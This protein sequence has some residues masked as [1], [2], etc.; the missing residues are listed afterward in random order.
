MK[1]LKTECTISKLGYSF[2][3]FRSEPLCV[4]GMMD[5]AV[6]LERCCAVGDACVGD[7]LAEYTKGSVI[8][9]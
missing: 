4:F 3:I 5:S 6:V 2:G 1:I 9:A 8:S 7:V